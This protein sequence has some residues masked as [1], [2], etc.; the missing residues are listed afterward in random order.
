MSKPNQNHHSI[1]ALSLAL[2][3]AGGA[4]QLM[5]A[6]TFDA[7]RGAL[8]G[9]G[10]WTLTGEAAAKV[11][12]KVAARKNDIVIDYEHQTLL[13]AK[14]G[15][16]APA[17]GWIKPDS[18]FFDPNKGLLSAAF[19]WTA[20][21]AA[22]IAAD[23][24]RYLSPVFAYD[25]ITG[26]VRDL[27]NVA[28]LN[29]PAIDGMDAVTLAAASLFYQPDEE[30]PVAITTTLKKTL[31]LADTAT[32][33]ELIQAV[34]ALKAKADAA[35]AKDTEIAALKAKTIDPAGFVP[36]AVV[37][38]LQGQ[39]AALS[40]KQEKTEIE[41]LIEKNM[42]KLPTPGLQQW[43]RGQSI[44]ALSAYLDNAPEVAALAGMQTAG[45]QPGGDSALSGD[46]LVAACKSQW[47]STPSIRGEFASLEDYTAYKKAEA[48]GQ[49][50][51]HGAR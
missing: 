12:A 25:E 5:P 38:E 8:A 22:A 27:I 19:K 13:S 6:G 26:E 40:A 20:A 46:A 35:S 23:E 39:L 14:N 41:Q 45:K 33:E 48:A 4:L 7:A 1:A 21:A 10:P 17:A 30:T 3:S 44:A 11:I 31:G 49:I 28:L 29:S 9:Q 51:I 16:P 2:P 32:D 47:D 24:F 18:L 50:K 34:E 43:A 42:T 36:I 37:T 15:K